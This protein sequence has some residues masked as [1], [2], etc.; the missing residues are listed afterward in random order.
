MEDNYVENRVCALINQMY[1]KRPP[2]TDVNE[3]NLSKLEDIFQFFVEM[4]IN[5]ENIAYEGNE[6]YLYL[7]V[8]ERQSTGYPLT[9]CYEIFEF[10]SEIL[11]TENFCYLLQNCMDACTIRAAENSDNIVMEIRLDNVYSIKLTPRK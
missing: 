5:E 9:I 2:D 8:G 1:N 6:T 7:S 4:S 11:M 10:D 3:K